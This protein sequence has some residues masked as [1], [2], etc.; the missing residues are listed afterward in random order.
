MPHRD[1]KSFSWRSLAMWAS[2]DTDGPAEVF[3]KHYVNHRDTGFKDGLRRMTIEDWR[4]MMAGNQRAFSDFQ[5]Q[6]LMQIAEGDL[7]ATRWQFT[8]TRTGGQLDRAANGEQATWTGVQIDR[9]EDGK[10][11][12]SWIDWD[13]H[14]LVQALGLPTPPQVSNDRGTRGRPAPSPLRRP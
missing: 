3:A 7:V 4:A 9:L 8:A 13:K 10:I 5:V 11:V 6:I 2:G 1:D 14:R 12:E